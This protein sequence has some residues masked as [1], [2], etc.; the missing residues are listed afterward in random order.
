MR[1]KFSIWSDYGASTRKHR[2]WAAN[3]AAPTSIGPKIFLA[4]VVVVATVIGISGLYPKVIDQTWVQ[5]AV[6]T[7]PPKMSLASADAT[8]KVPNIV[9]TIPVPPHRAVT[10]GR[11]TVSP[12]GAAPAPELSRLRISVPTIESPAVEP[13][14]VEPPAGA[15][16]PLALAAI[17]DAEAKT[18]AL[19]PDRA[20][21]HAAEPTDKPRGTVAKKNVVRVERHQ[22]GVAGPFA[23]YL[24]V[25]TKLARSKELK[26]ALRSVL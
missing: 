16:M 12:P 14:A 2:M 1:P 21:A 18:Y 6:G 20:V 3:R 7:D 5:N 11:A 23:Q 19:P 8:P 24:Q 25:L 22:H 10:A 26:A 17:P 13:P 15:A 9:A 4:A